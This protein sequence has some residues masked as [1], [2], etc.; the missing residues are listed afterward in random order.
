MVGPEFA[1][2]P[3]AYLGT[4]PVTG[5]DKPTEGRKASSLGERLFAALGDVGASTYR[6]FHE[7]PAARQAMYERAAVSF[8]ASLTYAE[9]EGVRE[10]LLSSVLLEALTE[11]LAARDDFFTIPEDFP[12]DA[13]L[14][15]ATRPDLASGKARVAI[16][17]A[18]GRADG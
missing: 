5:T 3:E 18:E 12:F 6:A 17:Q 15:A 11:L 13:R 14:A 9:S 2:M 1:A 4:E 7:M 16:A 8:T 10:A